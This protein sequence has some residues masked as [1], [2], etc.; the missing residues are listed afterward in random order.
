MNKRIKKYRLQGKTEAHRNSLIMGQIIELVRAEQIKTT[1]TKARIVKS[2]FDRLVTNAKK[3]TAAGD[4]EVQSF[5]RSNERAIERFNKVVENQL[6][7]RNSGYTR[8]VNTLPRKGDNAAQVYISLVNKG[9]KVEKK[10]AIEKTLETQE[11]K[12]KT[13]KAKPAAKK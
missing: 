5:F 10:S 12:K 2:Q 7:D 4:R 11:K 6:Q 13:K 3:K 9:E 1:P 8:V